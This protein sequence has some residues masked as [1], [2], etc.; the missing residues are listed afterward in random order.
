MLAARLVVGL[1]ALSV[2]SVALADVGLHAPWSV[3]TAGRGAGGD[4]LRLQP[5][6]PPSLARVHAGP[7]LV[8]AAGALVTIALALPGFEWSLGGRDAGTYVN[9]VVQIQERGAVEVTEPSLATVPPASGATW[10][11]AGATRAS[12]PDGARRDRPARVPY[13][14]G[15]PRSRRLRDRMTRAPGRWP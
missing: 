13:L 10:A 5:V 2:G 8:L 1:A 4:R 3:A 6:R 9:E 7:T 15:A 11:G 14:A 12:M